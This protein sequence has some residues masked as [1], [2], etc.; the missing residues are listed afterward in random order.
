MHINGSTRLVGRRIGNQ[1]HAQSIGQAPDVTC[2]RRSSD[3]DV[4]TNNVPPLATAGSRC[5]RR[6]LRCHGGPGWKG[7]VSL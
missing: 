1:Q 3:A 5:R 4:C 2:T 6:R 7:S